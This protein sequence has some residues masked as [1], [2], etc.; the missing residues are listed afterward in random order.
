MI[1]SVI[2]AGFQTAVQDCGR[3]GL[4]KFGV[5]PGGALDSVS[6]RLANLL[7]GNPDCMAGLECSSG[8]VRL[9]VDVD[10]LV[11]WAGGEF[12]I[13]VGDDLIP[14]LHCARVSAG[15]AIEISPKRGGRAWLAISGGVDVP[16][17]LGSRA[18]DLRAHFGGWAGRV[19]RDGDE[20]PLGGESK[21]CSRMR[22]EISD[23]VSDWS[24][25]RFVPRGRFLRVVRGKNWEDDIGEKLLAQKIP[26]SNE[27]RS[28]G[29]ATGRRWDFTA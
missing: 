24:A 12:E 25:P 2:L 14:I 9:K 18:T 22:K 13:R 7:V 1:A 10:R 15:A 19:L 26:R 27:F 23:V 20:L 8:R 6:L 11:A 21:L 28:H 5:T 17:I 16:E 29:F 3:V 4:R